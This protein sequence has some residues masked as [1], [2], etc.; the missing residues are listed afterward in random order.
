MRAVVVG[1]LLAHSFYAQDCCGGND[2]RPVSCDEIRSDGVGWVWKF[3]GEDIAFS[4]AMLRVS[5]DGGCHVCVHSVN[6]TDFTPTGTCIYLPPR[7]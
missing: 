1:V 3:L 6:A 7:T 4:R 2:C 5:Q